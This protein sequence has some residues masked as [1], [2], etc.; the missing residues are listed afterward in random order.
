MTMPQ[1]VNARERLLRPKQSPTWPEDGFASFA[2]TMPQG[3]IA[4]ERPLRP[5]QSPTW[6]ED[7]FASLAMTIATRCHCEGALFATEAIS[8]LA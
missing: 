6:P 7:G 1:V 5:K 3:V 4:R 2:M 8:N